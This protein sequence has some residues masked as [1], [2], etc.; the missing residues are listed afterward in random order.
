MLSVADKIIKLDNILVN[1]ALGG[2][3]QRQKYILYIYLHEY[4]LHI[5]YIYM[6]IIQKSGWWV[7]DPAGPFQQRAQK[8]AGHRVD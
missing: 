5:L 1:I 2:S 4:I 8:A 6:Y 7:A 3:K